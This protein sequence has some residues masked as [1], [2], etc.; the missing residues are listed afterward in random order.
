MPPPQL[1]AAVRCLLWPVYWLLLLLSGLRCCQKHFF[2][3]CELLP[4]A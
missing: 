1:V 4:Q 2:P 3:R